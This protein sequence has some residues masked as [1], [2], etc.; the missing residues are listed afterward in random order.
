MRIQIG[1]GTRASKAKT[2]GAALVEGV[3]GSANG[4]PIDGVER[5]EIDKRTARVLVL[6]AHMAALA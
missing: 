2:A 6:M 3:A 4:V 1:E 5:M